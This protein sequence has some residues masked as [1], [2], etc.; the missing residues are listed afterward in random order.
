MCI[1]LNYNCMEKFE[2]D[3]IKKNKRRNIFLILALVIIG[4]M[5]FVM[6][7][8]SIAKIKIFNFDFKF[9]LFLGIGFA[10]FGFVDLVLFSIPSKKEKQRNL[11]YKEIKQV[12]EKI[13]KDE[14][15]RDKAIICE[16]CGECVQ[17]NKTECPYCGAKLK[18]KK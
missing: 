2:D 9:Q 10:L 18:I 6:F 14:K 5:G 8:L 1:L 3:F 16:Y 15:N 4:L 11:V 17:G 13:L 12:E 7:F